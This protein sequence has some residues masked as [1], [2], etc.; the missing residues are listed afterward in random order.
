MSRGI[1]WVVSDQAGEARKAREL[2]FHDQR[3]TEE[4]RQ[5]AAKYYA[6]G[7]GKGR[8][9][10]LVGQLE[11]GARVL[12]YGCGTGSLAFDLAEVGA[13]VIAID[14]S[15]V[16]I[17]TARSQAE[18][19]GVQ[20]RFQEMDA[21]QLE[22]LTARSIWCVAQGSSTTTSI[23]SAR[24]PRLPGCLQPVVRVCSWSHSGTILRSTSTAA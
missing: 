20:I 1:H 3:F 23:S 18:P 19:R 21:E 8:S 22:F 9:R 14:I 4:S 5:R 12:E 6:I 17:R 7:A 10:E 2:E 24:S 13:S 11:T 15:P 16:A